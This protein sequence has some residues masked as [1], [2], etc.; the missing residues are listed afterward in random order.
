M[1]AMWSRASST[2]RGQRDRLAF[3]LKMSALVGLEGPYEH[4]GPLPD[5]DHCGYEVATQMLLQSLRPG[6]NSNEYTQFDTIRS[7]CTAHSNQVRAIR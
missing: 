1:D 5:H 6:K 3:G 2:V 7:T 4:H